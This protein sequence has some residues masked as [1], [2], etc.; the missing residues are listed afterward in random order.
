ME[1]IQNDYINWDLQ[2]IRE[3]LQELIEK[4][5]NKDL[6]NAALIF[7]E[8]IDSK[9]LLKKYLEFRW[10]IMVYNHILNDNR[11]N[12]SDDYLKEKKIDTLISN[13][14]LSSLA[15]TDFWIHDIN[16]EIKISE[17]FTK[18]ETLNNDLIKKFIFDE[19]FLRRNLQ[20]LL[21]DNK[22][23]ST[24]KIEKYLVKK[25]NEKIFYIKSELIKKWIKLEIEKK[26]D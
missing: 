3:N 26:I 16:S 19:A 14:I 4:S 25:L 7:L 6:I 15:W 23:E 1:L 8:I 10:L 20:S 5:D 9:D 13:I 21:V 11:F 24:E 2:E 12:I 22:S 17:V 18:N